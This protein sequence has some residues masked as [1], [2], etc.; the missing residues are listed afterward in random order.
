VR[1]IGEEDLIFDPGSDE[2]YSDL[3]Y[4]L[5]GNIIENIV[6]EKL[7]EYWSKTILSPL[8]L[9]NGLFFTKNKQTKG[10]VYGATGRCQW[11]NKE[12]CGLVNDDNCRL[13][14]GVAG[15]AGLFG[16]TDALMQLTSTLLR[17]YKGS[18]TH[19][20]ISFDLMREALK[21]KKGRWML[22]F[23]TPS[24]PVSSSGKYFSDKTIGHLGFTGTSF[25]LDC[26]E[27]RG[28]VVLTNRVL[29]DEDLTQ[30]RKFRPKIHDVVL[31]ILTSVKGK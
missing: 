24:R 23:D 19:P 21:L 17:M 8:K 4:I 15:H 12:L 9:E 20:A 11:S 5:L 6:E 26:R 1:S 10:K 18:Y 22:G 28:V 30:I 25:W 16:T 13:M 31:K 7:D 29:C 27:M 2:L 14:D 3:G